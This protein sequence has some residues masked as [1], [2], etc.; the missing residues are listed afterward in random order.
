MRR[1]IIENKPAT[2]PNYKHAVPFSNLIHYYF[3]YGSNMQIQQMNI[4][5]PDNRRVGF[6]TLPKYK[7]IINGRGYANV[8]R[9][10]NSIVEGTLF[11]VSNMDVQFLDMY[12]GVESGAYRR[13]I[14]PVLSNNTF[15]KAIVYI[16]AN[17]IEGQPKEEYIKR[18]NAGI[19][20][21]RLSTQYIAKYIRKFVPKD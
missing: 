8:I 2:L 9:C 12:E 16:D 21:A 18:I 14:I 1:Y 10:K 5:C 7:W 11:K 13:V 19:V 6:A 20:D 15:I 17:C 3:A 4:R